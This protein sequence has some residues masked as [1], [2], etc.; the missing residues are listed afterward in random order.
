MK[1]KEEQ[2]AFAD[3]MVRL[4]DELISIGRKMG[5][6]ALPDVDQRRRKEITEEITKLRN[7]YLGRA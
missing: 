5:V 2:I 4:T 6:D 3:E 1:T 7:A